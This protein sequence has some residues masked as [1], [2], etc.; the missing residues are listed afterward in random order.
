M[1]YTEAMDGDL[2]VAGGDL[3]GLAPG[4]CSDVCQ[5]DLRQVFRGIRRSRVQRELAQQSNPAVVI[6]A[7]VQ[8]ERL[9][10]QQGVA[11]FVLLESTRVAQV[12]T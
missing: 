12:L 8:G 2:D 1:G 9:V 3:Q 5:R 7:P 4:F 11:Y 10:D 6:P